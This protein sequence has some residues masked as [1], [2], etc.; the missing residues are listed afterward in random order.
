M[1]RG[2]RWGYDACK[3][4]D[5]AIESFNRIYDWVEDINAGVQPTG[6]SMEPTPPP[7]SP[8]SAGRKLAPWEREP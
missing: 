4:D 7:H 8:K 1:P 5:Y 6:V 3:D 2:F